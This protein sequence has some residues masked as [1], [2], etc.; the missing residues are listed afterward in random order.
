MIGQLDRSGSDGK[1]TFLKPAEV[2]FRTSVMSP[3]PLMGNHGEIFRTLE[4]LIF[5][6]IGSYEYL[7]AYY[8]M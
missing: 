4:G 1:K 3:T 6:V 5:E 2:C 8:P 7:Y